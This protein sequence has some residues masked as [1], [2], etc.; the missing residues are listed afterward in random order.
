MFD[1]HPMRAL[2]LMSKEPTNSHWLIGRW[3]KIW[4]GFIFLSNMT[5]NVFFEKKSI[6]H[7]KGADNSSLVDCFIVKGIVKWEKFFS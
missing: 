7:V 4:F 2:F 5:M 3:G 6:Q 1:L